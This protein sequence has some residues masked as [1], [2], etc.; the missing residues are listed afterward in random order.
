MQSTKSRRALFD[1]VVVAASAG[2]PN[3]LRRILALMPTDFPTPV[4]IVQHLSAAFE[5]S[6]AEYLNQDSG[7]PVC[8]ARSSEQLQRGYAY[9][10]PPGRH[11][12]I[13]TG[14]VCEL[15]SGPRVNFARPAAD[16]LFHSA[17]SCFGARTLGV[18]LTGRLQDGSRGAAAIRN[19]GGVMIV[20]HLD[21]CVAQ[22]MPRTA[23]ERGGANFVLS[24]EGIASAIICL[25]TVAG[26]RGIFGIAPPLDSASARLGAVLQ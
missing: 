24:P 20:Q 26:S 9:L 4:V 21:T 1:V 16:V 13:Q 6:L 18:V 23:M 3:V 25:V 11:M 19:A 2:G 8:W 10:A 22:G 17:V 7:L 15:S 5:S 14:G 12:T